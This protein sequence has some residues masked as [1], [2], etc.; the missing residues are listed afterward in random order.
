[1]LDAMLGEQLGAHDEAGADAA[2]QHG[3]N[4]D[5]D[6]DLDD[7]EAQGVPGADCRCVCAGP[8][9]DNPLPASSLVLFSMNELIG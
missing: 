2:D 8:H 6:D 1:M 7:R 4:S 5:G 3:D 9:G